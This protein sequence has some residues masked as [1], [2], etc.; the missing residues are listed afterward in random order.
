MIFEISVDR[1]R[2]ETTC[3]TIDTGE[4]SERKLIFECCLTTRRTGFYIDSF[5]ECA[6]SAVIQSHSTQTE[7][8]STQIDHLLYLYMG[9][10][11]CM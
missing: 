10:A 8:N 11:N 7:A 9:R 1:Q 3:Q 2:R 5:I 6:H 4:S